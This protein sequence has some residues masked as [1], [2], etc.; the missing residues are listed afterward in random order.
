MNVLTKQGLAYICVPKTGSSALTEALVPWSSIIYTRKPSCHHMTA[1]KFQEHVVPFHREMFPDTTLETFCVI[2]EPLSW[3]QSWYKYRSRPSISKQKNWRHIY[4]CG[5]LSFEEYALDV[6]KK[7]QPGHAQISTQS[8]YI[9]L[10]DGSLGVDK[11]FCMEDGMEKVEAYVSDKLIGKKFVI[12]KRNVSPQRTIEC[13]EE[14]QARLLE[15]FAE[16]ARLY[17]SQKLLSKI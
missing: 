17:D 7:K 1:Q 3:I 15:K 5:H 4:Y 12:P 8:R 16:D 6:L 14:I 11:I 9:K 10:D 13:S 2:R